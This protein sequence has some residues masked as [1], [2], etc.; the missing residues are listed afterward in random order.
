[1]ETANPAIPIPKL[2]PIAANFVDRKLIGFMG[3]IG[4]LPHK[5]TMRIIKIPGNARTRDPTMGT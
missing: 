2:I 3:Y 1:M 4:T 5:E